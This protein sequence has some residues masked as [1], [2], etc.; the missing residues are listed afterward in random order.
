M[1]GKAL[2][3]IEEHIHAATPHT[4]VLL[5]PAPGG[6]ETANKTESV[7]QQ[8]QGAA[9]GAPEAHNSGQ[10][11]GAAPGPRKSNIRWGGC[12]LSRARGVVWSGVVWCGVMR[13]DLTWHSVV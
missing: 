3:I 7:C 11:Q 8:D 12:L 4:P 1:P 5:L 10:D 13:H 9:P 6:Q 2:G